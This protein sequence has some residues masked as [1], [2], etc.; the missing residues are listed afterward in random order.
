MKIEQEMLDYLELDEFV[1]MRARTQRRSSKRKNAKKNSVRHE[2]A[3]SDSEMRN[4]ET[5]KV[6]LERLVSIGALSRVGSIY[7]AN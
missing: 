1:R 4:Y 5:V 7:Y 2:I 3:I 6:F